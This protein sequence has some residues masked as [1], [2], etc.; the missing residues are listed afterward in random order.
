MRVTV[1]V[2]LVVPWLEQ[3]GGWTHRSSQAAQTHPQPP[4]G[5]Q[6]VSV[7]QGQGSSREAHMLVPRARSQ[8]THV[9]P[10]YPSSISWLS[11][12]QSEH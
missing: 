12:L 4:P 6:Q 9:R 5:R 7:S 3:G 8:F 10:L 1:A 2:V 11:P